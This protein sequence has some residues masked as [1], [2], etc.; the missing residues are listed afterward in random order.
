MLKPAELT[1][2]TA[3]ALTELADRAGL[4]DGALNV[5]LG[6]APA[7]GVGGGIMNGFAGPV[8]GSEMMQGCF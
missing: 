6:D 3:M 5:V 2:L 1:P 7:I 8:G 4:L